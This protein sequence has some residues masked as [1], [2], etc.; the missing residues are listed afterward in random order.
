MLRFPGVMPPHPSALLLPFLPPAT[1]LV[2]IAWLFCI[3]DLSLMWRTVWDK[4]GAEDVVIWRTS[5]FSPLSFFNFFLRPLFCNYRIL[6]TFFCT[7]KKKIWELME[8]NNFF[9]SRQD[10]HQRHWTHSLPSGH[11]CHRGMTSLTSVTSCRVFEW[12]KGLGST[13]LMPAHGVQTGT[14]GCIFIFLTWPGLWPPMISSSCCAT[15]ALSFLPK[16]AF[17]NCTVSVIILHLPNFALR[18]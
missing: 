10:H 7:L 2:L 1:R 6:L 5:A 11:W 14:K 15:V 9:L 16:P 8:I 18:F 12:R 17:F 3:L 4:A 13:V